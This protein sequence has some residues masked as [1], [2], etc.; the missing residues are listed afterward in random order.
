MITVVIVVF[1][2]ACVAMIREPDGVRG[3]GAGG[4]VE[5]GM[6]GVDEATVDEQVVA[7]DH[8]ARADDVDAVARTRAQ[9]DGVLDHV[10][11]R[12]YVPVLRNLPAGKSP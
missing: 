3:S 4:A 10:V 11:L 5:R 9:D 8:E 6:H 12:M 2:I 1:L 7:G